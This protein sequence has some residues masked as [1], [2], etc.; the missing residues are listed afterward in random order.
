MSYSFFRCTLEHTPEVVV[1]FK[2]QSLQ[3]C[4]ELLQLLRRVFFSAE[5]ET[6]LKKQA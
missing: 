4:F 3:K 1:V 6:K 5:K 2:W